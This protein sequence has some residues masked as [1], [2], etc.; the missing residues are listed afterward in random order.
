MQH[1]K[2]K[3]AYIAEYYVREGIELEY[4][5]LVPN[6]GLKQLAKMMLNSMWGNCVAVDRQRVKVELKKPI[7]TG[8][9]VLELSKVLMYEFHYEYIKPKYGDQ[10]QLRRSSCQKSTPTVKCND[11]H[12]YFYGQDC[13]DYRKKSSP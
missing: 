1:R 8:F 5:K 13:F 2:K 3:Q 9:T 7:Y 12:R 4:E 11:C 6:R 10:A